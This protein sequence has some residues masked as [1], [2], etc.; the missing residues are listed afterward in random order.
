MRY[1][2]ILIFATLYS[3]NPLTAQLIRPSDPPSFTLLKKSRVEMPSR[4]YD[5]INTNLLIQQDRE[6]P[7]PMRY[8]ICRDLQIDLQEVGLRDE[9]QEKGFIRRFLI[10]SSG[11]KAIGLNLSSF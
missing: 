6:F 9:L 8:G 3:A 11:A 4:V 1:L 10:V 7:L 5:T 2:I